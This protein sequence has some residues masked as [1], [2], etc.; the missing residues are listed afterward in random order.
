MSDYKVTTS[1]GQTLDATHDS[2]TAG[3][4][5]RACI[6][7]ANVGGGFGNAGL[8]VGMGTTTISGYGLATGIGI[9]PSLIGLGLGF[10]VNGLSYKVKTMAQQD[11]DKCDATYL[12]AK[13]H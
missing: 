5:F 1:Q 8:T 10:G 12:R 9:I 6:D 3:Q 11:A 13:G 2:S 4:E 7:D